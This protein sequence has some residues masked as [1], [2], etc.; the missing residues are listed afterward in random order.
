MLEVTEPLNT[1]VPTSNFTQLL[2]KHFCIWCCLMASHSIGHYSHCKN[3][4]AFEAENPSR[5]LVACMYDR[6]SQNT[7]F[8]QIFEHVTTCYYVMKANFYWKLTIIID[9]FQTLAFSF[10]W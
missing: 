10:G 1:S 6:L 7:F 3:T 2:N 9:F 5:Y 8:I 4:G